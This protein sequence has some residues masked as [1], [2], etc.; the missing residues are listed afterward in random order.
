MP[1]TADLAHREA[2][3]AAVTRDL[4]VNGLVDA[5]LDRLAAAAGTSARMLVHHFGSRQ[6]LLDTAL[7][8]CRERELARARTELPAVPD[9]LHVLSRAWMWFAS[10]EAGQYF[11]LFGQLAA[12]SRLGVDQPGVSRA[13]LST[14]WLD[15]FS[16]GFLASGCGRPEARRLA[17]IVVA[18]V[19]G[20]L[21]DLDVTGDK[22]R[23]E[24]A[25]KEF[26]A[27]LTL[28]RDLPPES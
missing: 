18:Q 2:L 12:S 19:R 1:R 11:R 4:L 26:I 25:Y 24:G 14:E 7:R 10:D 22:Q 21:L 13:Q 5:S 6:A 27:L 15:I 23:V 20:L 9:F 8:R 17:T 16:D 3:L 28:S